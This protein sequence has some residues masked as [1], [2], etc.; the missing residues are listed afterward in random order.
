LKIIKKN[1]EFK[2]AADGSSAS[3]K[4]T[5]G[6]II[7]KNFK[8]EFLSSGTLYRY[9]ALKIINSKKNC[10]KKLIER[11]AASISLKKLKDKEIKKAGLKFLNPNEAAAFLN[12]PTAPP[13]LKRSSGELFKK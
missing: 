7:A 2:I 11:I 8:M 4:T 5:A 1:I 13:Q 9:C 12:R 10:N 3:G 6:K